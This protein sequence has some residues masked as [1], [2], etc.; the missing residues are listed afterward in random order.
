[1][2][3]SEEHRPKRAYGSGQ[4]PFHRKDKKHVLQ[5]TFPV[6]PGVVVYR[7]DDHIFFA[8]ACPASMQP[9]YRRGDLRAS[10]VT[11]TR[12]G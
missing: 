6:T 3:G 10:G 1:M 2:N 5:R 9:P 8:S 12:S 7:L 11:F 4:S